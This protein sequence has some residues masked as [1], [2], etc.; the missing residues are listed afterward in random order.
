M[1]NKIQQRFDVKLQLQNPL[2][3]EICLFHHTQPNSL[4]Q[5]LNYGLDPYSMKTCERGV[6]EAAEAEGITDEE[7]I[8]EWLAEC[9][10]PSIHARTEL[11]DALSRRESVYFIKN[12]EN[13]FAHPTINTVV[14]VPAELI[15]CKC[16]EDNY[17]LENELYDFIY[18][19][20]S[21]WSPSTDEEVIWKAIEKVE[22]SMRPLD[23]KKNDYTTEVLCPCHI[24][25]EII[26]PYSSNKYGSCRVME[27]ENT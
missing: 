18:G 26:A 22:A 5:I 14:E 21:D 1:G 3:P 15:P 27:L 23:T 17:E 9:Q 25:P 16:T 11:D 19:Q 4:E 7:E 13:M 20:Y 6:Y 24:P 10:V 2:N 12:K 8:G